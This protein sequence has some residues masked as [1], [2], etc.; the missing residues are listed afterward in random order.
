MDTDPTGNPYGASIPLDKALDPRCD[1]ILAYEMNE[2]TLPRDHGFPLRVVIPGVVGARS[3]KW[4]GTILRDTPS[5]DA[6]NSVFSEGR[7]VISNEESESH[8]QRND[9]KGFAPNVDWNTV[10]FSKSPAI[11]EMPVNSAI[12]EPAEGDAIQL[13]E[14]KI[15]AKG[16]I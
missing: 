13:E 16:I 12:C 1:V 2:T 4:L 3:V 7:I 15:T 6:C 11:Q 5:N 14:G 8:W 9:Y 10:D